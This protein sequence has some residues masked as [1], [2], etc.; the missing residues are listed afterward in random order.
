MGPFF[1]SAKLISLAVF[2][3]YSLNGGDMLPDLVFITIGLF[4]AVRL[5][6]TLFIPFAITFSMETRVTIKRA[7]VKISVSGYC[8]LFPT[9][10]RWQSYETVRNNS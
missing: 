8:V 5:A 6:T 10:E 9:P 4:Q 1:V 2:V 7:E 3:A